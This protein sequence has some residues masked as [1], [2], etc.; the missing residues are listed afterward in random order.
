MN[1]GLPI[2]V[3]WKLHAFRYDQLIEW[4]QR[5]DLTNKFYGSENINEQLIKLRE[6]Q[7]IENI[8]HVLIKR[9]NLKILCDDLINHE[10]F[11]LVNVKNCYKNNP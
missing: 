6:I 10:I 9:D 8:S 5:I 2:F 3:D 4:Q 7:E 11:S 1:S